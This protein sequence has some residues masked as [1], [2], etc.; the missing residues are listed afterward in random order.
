MSQARSREKPGLRKAFGLGGLRAYAVHSC[1]DAL[2]VPLTGLSQPIGQVNWGEFPQ[3]ES[4]LGT[5]D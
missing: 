3:H 5:V 4:S 2:S 1:K